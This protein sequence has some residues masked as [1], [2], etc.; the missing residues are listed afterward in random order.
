LSTDGAHYALKFK[1]LTTDKKVSLL[2]FLLSPEAMYA[3]IGLFIEL[4]G[5]LPD[6]WR[7]APDGSIQK[8]FTDEELAQFAG[9]VR[10]GPE[11]EERCDG[12]GAKYVKKLFR[13][14]LFYTTEYF[15][16]SCAE[17]IATENMLDGVNV[18]FSAM[19]D[20]AKEVVD[21]NPA[22]T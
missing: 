19:E 2:H 12:C 9:V 8:A 5:P 20:D 10:C 22:N 1:S 3:L 13:R 18:D 15:C 21:S 7:W 11:V 14:E 4:K 17:R 6:G 16:R